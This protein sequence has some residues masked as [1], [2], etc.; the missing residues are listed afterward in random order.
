MSNQDDSPQNNLRLFRRPASS[1]PSLTDITHSFMQ[2]GQAAELADQ[3]ALN[4]QLS[5]PA[6]SLWRNTSTPAAQPTVAP[7]GLKLI[8]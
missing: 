8:K 4:Q 6:L 5:K 7:S 1:E 2:A 3:R